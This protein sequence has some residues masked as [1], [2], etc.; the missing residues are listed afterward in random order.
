MTNL[1]NT[2]IAELAKAYAP[3]LLFDPTERFFP[4]AAEEWLNHRAAERWD[5]GPTHERGTAIIRVLRSATAY[6]QADVV[7]GSDTPSGGAIQLSNTPPDGIGQAFAFDP[8]V[9]DLFLD[10]AGW[11]DTTTEV[12]PGD[13][14]FTS[15]SPTYLD[16]LFRNLGNAMNSAIPLDTPA[17]P[18][19]FTIARATTPTIYAEAEWAGRYPR[20]DLARVAANGDAPDFPPMIGSAAGGPGLLTA[21]DAYLV[22]H[23][24]FLY[25]TMQ[26]TPGTA[27]DPS[28][29]NR[30]GQW[31]AVSIYLK[32]NT[33]VSAHDEDGR[34]DFS[35]LGASRDLFSIPRFVV[36][37]RGYNLGDDNFAPLAAEARP[38]S[39]PLMRPTMAVKTVDSHAVVYVAAGT[40]HNLFDIAAGK[41]VGQSQPDPGLNTSGGAAMGVAGTLAGVCL[42]LAPPPLTVACIV[43]LIIAAVIFLIG[44]ILFLLSFLLE[45]DPP[46]TETPQSSDAGSDLARDGGPASIPPGAGG[47]PSPGGLPP[48][49]RVTPTVRVINRF[50]FGPTPPVNTFPPGPNDVELPFW[51]PF[52]GR[53]G[54]RV[55]NRASGQWD[56]G[57]R[58]VD[59][60]ERSRGYWN[61]Y[62]LVGFLADPARAADGISA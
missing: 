33:D 8:S 42:A 25:P 40:H 5:V 17:P 43:C 21:L 51:W 39:D 56:S 59:Q 29:R 38:W 4:V 6:S 50:K 55:M 48:S 15:G 23:Y 27:S 35:G 30:E 10:C 16:K 11:E 47:P 57:T 31:E 44:L 7:A 53:W 54:I 24:Y 41:T 60:F 2:K 49:S 1:T 18:P 20:L 14:S 52:A 36:Y 19:A 45:S 12:A 9:E 34:P 62:Q 37:S 3:Y 58:R 61:T 28:I 46:V 26:P 13:P 22:L 32:S